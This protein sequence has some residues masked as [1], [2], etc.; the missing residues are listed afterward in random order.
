MDNENKA[1]T[2]QADDIDKLT[3]ESTYQF[4][5]QI[6][7]EIFQK[8]I[9]IKI[10]LPNIAAHLVVRKFGYTHH[11]LYCGLDERNEP[12]II[13][14]SGLAD[15]LQAGPVE[16]ISL[17]N[18]CSGGSVYM[19][20]H[21][22][23]KFP[24]EESV[25]RAK[26]RLGEERYNLHSNNC[27]HFVNWCISGHHFSDQVTGAGKVVARIGTRT[28][29]RFNILTNVANEVL[30]LGKTFKQWV[31][32]DIDD[33][34]L[35][36]EIKHA[37]VTSG[38][39][40][41][42]GSLGQAAIPIP[43]VGFLV[44]SAVGYFVGHSLVKSGHVA[45]GETPAVKEARERAERIKAMCER[46]IPEIKANRA[47][48]EAYIETHFANRAQIFKASFDTLDQ[49]ILSDEPEAFVGALHTINDQFGQTLQFKTFDEFDALME[50]D[51]PLRF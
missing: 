42:Y 33:E 20:P 49:A 27:E 7:A 21:S 45:I 11:G 46:L 12:Y 25:Q 47:K 31:D 2:T 14:Y 41:W 17:Q 50:S 40:F 18:F 1:V 35:I 3:S 37:A 13:H 32:N 43:G 30:H 5:D 4:I 51:D 22:D 34:K 6:L 16:V 48:L 44:G 23:R 19:Q 38:S 15:G 8:S 39:M 9:D 29:T 10:G 36:S 26:E 24:R 28:L